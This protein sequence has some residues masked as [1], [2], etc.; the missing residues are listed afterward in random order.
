MTQCLQIA[1]LCFCVLL[2]HKIADNSMYCIHEQAGEDI[3][4]K[5]LLPNISVANLL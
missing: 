3:S 4:E 1:L 2:S 5:R